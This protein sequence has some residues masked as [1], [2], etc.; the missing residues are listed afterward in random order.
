[1]KDRYETFSLNFFALLDTNK[2][3]FILNSTVFLSCISKTSN[4]VA[5]ICECSI[6]RLLLRSVDRQAGKLFNVGR[7]KTDLSGNP[8]ETCDF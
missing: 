5:Q 6:L 1:M 7:V 3:E 8:C 4:F 2:I